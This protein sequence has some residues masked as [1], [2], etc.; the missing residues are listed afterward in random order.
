M[1]DLHIFH[2]DRVIYE[3]E[4]SEDIALLLS[5]AHRHINFHTDRPDLEELIMQFPTALPGLMDAL[6]KLK[7][8]FADVEVD[9]SY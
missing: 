2:K 9:I 8:D 6:S 4:T 5:H 1:A 7:D 3:S